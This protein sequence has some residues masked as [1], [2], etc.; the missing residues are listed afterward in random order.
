MCASF[1]NAD[2]RQDLNDL[3]QAHVSPVCMNS[4]SDDLQ[5]L[6]T[7]VM[8]VPWFINTFNSAL[9]HDLCD[10]YML[11]RGDLLDTHGLTHIYTCWLYIIAFVG[12]IEL[13]TGP[14]SH[15]T[16]VI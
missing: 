14:R 5:G 12:Y 16:M 13:P 15:V 3:Y 8:R 2:L 4:R 10:I 9:R 6:M 1:H 7:F 11:P